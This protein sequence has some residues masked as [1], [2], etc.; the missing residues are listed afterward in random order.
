MR[1]AEG[2]VRFSLA[3]FSEGSIV[4]LL[5]IVCEFWALN[6]NRVR[7][8]EDDGGVFVRNGG[9]V[10][11]YRQDGVSETH[12]AD[13]PARLY[14]HYGADFTGAQRV[15][16]IIKHTFIDSSGTVALNDILKRA[17]HRVGQFAEDAGIPLDRPDMLPAADIAAV[18]VTP[19]IVEIIQMGGDCLAVWQ[20]RD[21]TI[22][23]TEN[24]CLAFERY[25]RPWR[26]KYPG[27]RDFFIQ[28][29]QPFRDA[30]MLFTNKPRSQGGYATLNGQPEACDHWERMILPRDEVALLLLFT[31]GLV[32]PEHL[33]HVD[34][35]A[36]H[37]IESYREGGWPT[38]L[39]KRGG[40]AATNEGVGT[41]L[42]FPK[43]D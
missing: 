43:G 42:V 38:I 24:Q 5:P 4:M 17:N 20:M 3:F 7:H 30:R 39:E 16:H 11:A 31:D 28:A 10:D 12:S 13:K 41:A 27:L 26:D 32:M 23:Y 19:Q 6:N 35:S 25:L 36:K 40:Q 33:Y 37:M 14:N 22:G 29:E 8:L 21:G 1:C 18:R 34:Q 2:S 9:I 15:G